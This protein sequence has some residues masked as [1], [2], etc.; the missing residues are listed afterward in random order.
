[1]VSLPSGNSGVCRY[2]GRGWE[3][4]GAFMDGL[5]CDVGPF[6]TEP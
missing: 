2:G 6:Y 3:E 4:R 1:V 5:G